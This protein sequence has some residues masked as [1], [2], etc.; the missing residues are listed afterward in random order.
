MQRLALLQVTSREAALLGAVGADCED[1]KQNPER[2][3]N[4]LA[5]LAQSM[6]ALRDRSPERHRSV[7]IRL[8]PDERPA[9]TGSGRVSFTVATSPHRSVCLVKSALA[10]VRTARRSH[11]ERPL[12]EGSGRSLRG[13]KGTAKPPHRRSSR[14]SRSLGSYK[15]LALRIGNRHAFARL[16][17]APGT[18]RAPA[19]LGPSKPSTSASRPSGKPVPS[20]PAGSP[21][22]LIGFGHRR[23]P[24]PAPKRTIRSTSPTPV[25]PP[26]EARS[27]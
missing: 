21:A 12:S 6:A 7:T 2:R 17:G 27:L 9:H 13:P 5:R 26:T 18:T 11:S 20:A 10:M 24:S 23:R 8:S 4:R 15:T 14:P 16:K 22:T 25:P 1:G 19:L 3:Q